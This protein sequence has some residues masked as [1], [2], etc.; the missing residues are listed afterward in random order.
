IVDVDEFG[1]DGRAMRSVRQAVARIERAGYHCEIARQR[2]LPPGTLEEARRA[3]AALRAGTVE[4]GFSMAL[5]RAADPADPDNLLVIG[6]DGDG[7]VRGL[8]Q[9]VPWGGDGLSLDTMRH[10]RDA[11]N[12]LVEFMVV[13]LVRDAQALGVRHV[14]L[15]FAMLRSVFDRAGRLG[16]G[17]VL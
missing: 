2:D 3:A 10:D 5:S 4:R 8:L 15:N 13:A 11:H 9:F 17:P 14:S 16:A 1:L 6:R 7:R 12:G